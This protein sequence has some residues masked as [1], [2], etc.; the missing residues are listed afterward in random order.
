MSS[1]TFDRFLGPSALLMILA[2][3][4]GAVAGYSGIGVPH[5]PPV[6]W[7]YWYE[8]AWKW[9]F[10]HAGFVGD[11]LLI[12]AFSAAVAGFR[13]EGWARRAWAGLASVCALATLALVSYCGFLP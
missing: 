6:F 7:D 11:M 8:S 2:A 12:L 5:E 4:L 3:G 10:F 1:S 9:A 13:T